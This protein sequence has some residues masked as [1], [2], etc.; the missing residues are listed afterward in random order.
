MIKVNN[1]T[2]YKKTLMTKP[3]F[4]M[5]IWSKADRS[6]FGCSI[7]IRR[8]ANPHVYIYGCHAQGR[9][10]GAFIQS[11]THYPIYAAVGTTHLQ[12][13]CSQSI[14]LLPEGPSE[15]VWVS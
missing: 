6:K 4:K 9:L 13:L 14:I 8:P 2:A 12:V 3:I 1:S 7:S 11:I 15:E 10:K 5:E